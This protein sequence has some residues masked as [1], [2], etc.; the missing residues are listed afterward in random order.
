MK[1]QSKRPPSLLPTGPRNRRLQI[2]WR[3][4]LVFVLVALVAALVVQRVEQS[5]RE[6]AATTSEV[7]AR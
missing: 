3:V 7:R 1:R 6:R 5:L 2:G 4:P